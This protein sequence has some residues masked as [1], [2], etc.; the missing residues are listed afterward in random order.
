MP[1]STRATP[2]FHKLYRPASLSAVLNRT[3]AASGHR[4]VRDGV[5][6]HLGAEWILEPRRDS[7]GE[8]G[9]VDG[10][11]RAGAAARVAAY[12]QK[13]LGPDPGVRSRAA[14]Q[15]RAR[16]RDSGR[17]DGGR[18]ARV[19]GVAQLVEQ[20]IRNQQ[21]VGSSPTAGSNLRSRLPRTR[22]LRLASHGKVVHRSP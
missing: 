8:G 7:R 22:E 5:G 20:L 15:V 10:G 3:A 4:P 9:R 18:P 1:F 11:A 17:R 19:A 12:R 6:P 21:V 2:P 14:A 13:P 16:I